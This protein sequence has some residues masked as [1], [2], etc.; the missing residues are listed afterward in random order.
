MGKDASRPS[1]SIELWRKNIRSS[2]TE[3]KL[4]KN[5]VQK[6]A[7]INATKNLAG[8]TLQK[9]VKQDKIS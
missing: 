2:A 7:I 4:F 1:D 5:A 6:R 9:A 8:R 3:V